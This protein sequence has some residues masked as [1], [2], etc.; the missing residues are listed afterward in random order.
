M[1][2][3]DHQPLRIDSRSD[4]QI[5]TEVIRTASQSTKNNNFL[6]R[7]TAIQPVQRLF[8]VGGLLIDYPMNGYLGF[9]GRHFLEGR[10]GIG[11]TDQYL[12][13]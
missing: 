1:A 4:H 8:E 11:I 10:E 5:R 6:G 9:L 2:V 3:K 13:K 12:R 7:S